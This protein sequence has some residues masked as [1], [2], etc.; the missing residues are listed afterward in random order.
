ME[1]S[2]I[3]A[4]YAQVDL[5][6]AAAQKAG[7]TPSELCELSNAM[8]KIAETLK[9]SLALDMFYPP[10]S[11][12]SN[13]T[14]MT[15][16]TTKTTK[17]I[18]WPEIK[19][20]AKSGTLTI[21][22]EIR[23]TLKNGVDTSV[24]VADVTGGR[25]YLVFTDLVDRRP[26]YEKF[27]NDRLSWKGSDLRKWANKE[28]ISELPDELLAI[29]I[30]REITQTIGGEKMST[31]DILWAPSATELFG[32]KEWAAG[33][34]LAEKQFPIF[35]TERSRVKMVGDE[36]WRYWTRSPTTS[37]ATY[38]AIANTDG[39]FGNYAAG[40]ASGVCLGLCV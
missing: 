30:P 10:S 1:K 28:F 7:V 16:L 3:A 15:T 23:F 4:L 11:E 37:V 17:E 33:D 35:K 25:A 39:S 21:G 2:I 34:D 36:T 9:N 18:Q 29:I 19:A 40:N 20:A 32:R 26:M 13:K 27:P 6:S 22:D 31:N 8:A 12:P 24:T 38:F 14:T 5:L